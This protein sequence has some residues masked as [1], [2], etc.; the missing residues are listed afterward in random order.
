MTRE[1]RSSVEKRAVA[2]TLTLS[3]PSYASK[4]PGS[5][6]APRTQVTPD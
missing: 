2:G 4:L 5:S 6:F 1:K 3:N